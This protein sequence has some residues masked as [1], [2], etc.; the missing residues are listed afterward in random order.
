MV[1]S[2]FDGQGRV[3]GSLVN[4]TPVGVLVFDTKT[5]GV[6]SVNRE[7]RRIVNDLCAPGGSAEQLLEVLTFRRFD[8]R[9]VSLE[10]FPLAKAL[11]TGE[12]VRAEEIVL[13][14]LLSLLWG[15]LVQ[16]LAD[17]PRPC[18]DSLC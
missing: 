11:G 14:K 5:G 18:K 10:E 3:A 9:D 12:T 7:A 2:R 8:G 16:A 17:V 6:T 13:Q 15:R 4:T 1:E